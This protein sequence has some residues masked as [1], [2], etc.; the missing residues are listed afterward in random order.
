MAAWSP[1]FLEFVRVRG[2]RNVFCEWMG[3]TR[4]TEYQHGRYHKCCL[5]GP[6]REVDKPQDRET[7]AKDFFCLQ[8]EKAMSQE[9]LH[10]KGPSARVHK[11]VH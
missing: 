6:P 1:A 7:T 8:E 5:I 9:R 2:I 10:V 3:S 4:T 11:S